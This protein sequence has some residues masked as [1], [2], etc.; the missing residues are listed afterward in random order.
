MPGLHFPFVQAT[1]LTMIVPLQWSAP[2]SLREFLALNEETPPI[3]V[4]F[5]SIKGHERVQL[6]KALPK[7]LNETNIR[8]IIHNSVQDDDE[9]LPTT[10][11]RLEGNINQD[12]LFRHGACLQSTTFP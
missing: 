8:A 1:C 10:V 4:A 2:G 5:G 11:Y 3:Y 6:L 12:W 7:A 9:E